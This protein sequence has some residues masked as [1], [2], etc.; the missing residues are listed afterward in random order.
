VA[1]I[2]TDQ[3][4]IVTTPARFAGRH[5]DEVMDY[6]DG[7]EAAVSSSSSHT[8][9]PPP[10][11]VAKTP[12][13]I[14]AERLAASSHNR[15]D[16]LQQMTFQRFEQDDEEQ[17]S[18]TVEDYDV[19]KEKIDKLKNTLH[20]AQ[21]AQKNLHRTLYINV[22]SEDPKVR[23]KIFAKVEADP[24]P[25]EGDEEETP[26]PSPGVEKPRV[27]AP[28]AARPGPRPAP[29]LASPTPASR[30]APVNSSKERK[31][32]LVAT[33]KI[34]SFCRATNQNL[35][36]YLMRLEDNGETQESLNGAGQMGR[37]E[38]PRSV[39]DRTKA[40]RS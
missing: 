23:G 28:A 19:Y 10:K 33:D 2:E 27:A 32:K 5:I 34:R 17:F 20:P 9:D 8:E 38:Q 31:P 29:P 40:V 4:G 36:A 1:K 24:P 26:P 13:Q 21:R 35:D 15:I 30:P 12:E 3:N 14:A 25:V 7:L 37:R 18:K 6:L 16:P 22:K 39:Y 11:P